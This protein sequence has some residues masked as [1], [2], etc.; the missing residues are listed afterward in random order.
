MNK[1]MQQLSIFVGLA[2]AL[3]LVVPSS[4]TAEITRVRMGVDG[5]I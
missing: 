5:M 4:G 3:A 1:R 2:L